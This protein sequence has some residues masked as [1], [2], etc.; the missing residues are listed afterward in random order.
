[1]YT[2]FITPNQNSVPTVSG[3]NSID[4][5]LI[6]KLTVGI[7]IIAG[8]FCIAYALYYWVKIASKNTD[9]IKKCKRWVAIGI[10]L[11]LITSGGYG[12]FLY[13]TEMGYLNLSL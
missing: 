12:L 1:M 7:L 2:A 10:V 4:Y 6:L 11:C 13:L 3:V 9:T 8:F 5:A